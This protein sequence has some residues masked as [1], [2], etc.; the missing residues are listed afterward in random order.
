MVRMKLGR[1]HVGFAVLV[2]WIVCAAAF[3][4]DYIEARL[5]QRESQDVLEPW[6]LENEPVTVPLAPPAPTPVPARVNPDTTAARPAAPPRSEPPAADSDVGAGAPGSAGREQILVVRCRQLLVGHRLAAERLAR[7]LRSGASLEEAR[8]AIGSIDIDDRTRDYAVDDLQPELR[9]EVEKLPEGA[10][11]GVRNWN[12]RAALFQVVSKQR[13]E[14]RSIPELGAGLDTDEQSRMA[15]VQRPV[16][17]PPSRP[18][19][20]ETADTEGAEVVNQVTPQYPEDAMAAGAVTVLVTV[21]RSDEVISV[22]IETSSDPV[23]NRAAQDAAHRSTYRAQRQGGTPVGGSVR[24]TF[25]F[26]AP[27]ALP[28]D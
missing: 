10:W 8:K 24:V 13:R 6:S 3:G 5:T 17:A 16:Q 12:G 7:L 4:T 15:R 27:Q 26:P 28:H 21:G 18:V 20:D 9:A 23:F 14:R 1:R 11:S 25:Q 22:D 19:A 2:T